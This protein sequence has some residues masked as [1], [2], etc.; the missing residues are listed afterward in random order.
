MRLLLALAFSLLLTGCRGAALPPAHEPAD[1]TLRACVAAKGFFR[2]GK[3]PE[4][5]PSLEPCAADLR[6]LG[7]DQVKTLLGKPWKKYDAGIWEYRGPCWGTC[8]GVVAIAWDHDR[9]IDV[10]DS[11]G[12]E[13]GFGGE[14]AR[15]GAFLERHGVA[16]K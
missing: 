4:R 6:G 13:A 7:R 10:F 3:G 16:E 14:A 12:F 9:V 8:C 1:E 5:R 11:R 15:Y 2:D